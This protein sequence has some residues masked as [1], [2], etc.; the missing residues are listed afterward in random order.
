LVGK[1]LSD[2]TGKKEY[3]P[4]TIMMKKLT[5]SMTAVDLKYF[6]ACFTQ[7]ALNKS[8]NDFINYINL[9]NCF[10]VTKTFSPVTCLYEVM[11]HFITMSLT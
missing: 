10:H 1:S 2:F 9:D 4:D 6:I 5:S 11:Y 3:V 7:T 8:F